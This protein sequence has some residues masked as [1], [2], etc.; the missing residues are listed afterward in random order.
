MRFS[1]SLQN[2]LTTTILATLFL[3]TPDSTIAQGAGLVFGIGV[4]TQANTDDGFGA[5]LRGRLSAPVTA[6]LSFAAG[7]GFSSHFLNGRN[8]TVFSFDPQISAILTMPGVTSAMYFMAGVGVYLSTGGNNGDHNGPTLH[9][10]IGGVRALKDGA[11]FYEIN[12][13]VIIKNTSLALSV[14]IR[15]GI[16]L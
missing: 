3:I 1:R 16:I 10:G 13:A 14:P 12:P 9:F 6:D 5:G 15:V 4:Q 2:A 7:L 11:L 8:E